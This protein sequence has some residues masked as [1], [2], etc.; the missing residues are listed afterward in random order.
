MIQK[1]PAH[2]RYTGDHGWLKTHWLFSFG[3]YYDPNNMGFGAL[4][5]FNDDIVMPQGGF[6]DHPHDTMEIVTI[7]LSGTLSHTDSMGN[8]AHITA[9]EVQRMS[10]GKG[11]VH[12]EYNK[13]DEPVHLYQIWFHPHTETT[14]DYEQMRI[15]ENKDHPLTVLASPEHEGG[16]QIYADAHMWRYSL[17]TELSWDMTIPKGWGHFVYVTEGELTING[18]T[19]SASDQARITDE[20]TLH[21]SGTQGSGIII[22]VKQ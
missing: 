2:K 21:Y 10:A 6:P 9:G 13:G 4:R 19:F 11:V 18:E 15:T 5:V 14:A 12:S 8:E 16:L 20:D 17:N 22:E 7:I 3:N 1:I